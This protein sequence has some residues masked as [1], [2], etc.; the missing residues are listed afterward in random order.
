MPLSYWPRTSH[1]S[2]R[3]CGSKISAHTKINIEKW[4][5]HH[6]KVNAGN[7]GFDVVC[8]NA[9]PIACGVVARSIVPLLNLDLLPI[10]WLVFA[11]GQVRFD[12]EYCPPLIASR[13]PCD[14]NI[15]AH[16]AAHLED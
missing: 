6:C 2:V 15:I 1:N 14:C 8:N 9:R 4:N 5:K 13:M 11:V 10:R 16:C 12:C 3:V 7:L